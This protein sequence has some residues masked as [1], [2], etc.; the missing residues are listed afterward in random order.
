MSVFW[1]V[2]G[3]LMWLEVG[4]IAASLSDLRNHFCEDDEKEGEDDA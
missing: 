2:L 1:I 4:S 3:V